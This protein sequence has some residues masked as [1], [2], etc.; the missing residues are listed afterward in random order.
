MLNLLI[1][2]AVLLAVGRSLVPFGAA[3]QQA[4]KVYRIGFLLQG[5]P[6]QLSQATPGLDAFWQRLRE[7][8]W[9]EGQNVATEVRW[10]EGNF[11]RLP[12]L[13]A[14]L[15]G[16]KVDVIVTVGFPSV[17]AAMQATSVIPIVNLLFGDAVG[18]GVAS[19]GRPGGNV[20]GTSIMTVEL[21]GKRLE[22]L[23][24]AIPG[25]ARVAVLR[26]PVVDGPPNLI[27][28]P[29]WRETQ[30]AARRLNLQLQS[31]EVRKPDDIERVF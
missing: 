31:L 17:Q 2:L 29:M 7:S 13:A 21:S 22:L 4:G 1:R 6:P 25:L 14:D 9:V 26:C 28:G 16:R 15:V 8:G 10:A 24:T 19:L 27:D 30:V 3:A 18:Q 11:D 20:T 12:D 23:R 5:S